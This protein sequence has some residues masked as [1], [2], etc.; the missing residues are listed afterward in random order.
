[1]AY[2]EAL[3]PP[4]RG[5]KHRPSDATWSAME[6]VLADQAPTAPTAPRKKLE[7]EEVMA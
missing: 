3:Q 6:R 2:V 5:R 4:R 1:M 7:P